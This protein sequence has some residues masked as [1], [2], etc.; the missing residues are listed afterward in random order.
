MSQKP[1]QAKPIRAQLKEA[2]IF[3]GHDIKYNLGNG[4]STNLSDKAIERFLKR[5][6]EDVLRVQQGEHHR[7]MF[8]P[9]AFLFKDLTEKVSKMYI[10][11]YNTV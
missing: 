8:V 10:A 7:V 9:D 6:L 4:A 3:K 5:E 11:N 2:F 1:T